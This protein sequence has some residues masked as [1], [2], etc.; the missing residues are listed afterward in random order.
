MSCLPTTNT[1]WGFWGTI[2]HEAEPATA[3]ATAMPAIA[4]ATGCPEEAVRDFLDSRHG[5]HFADDVS[6]DLAGGLGLERAIL[7]AVERWMGWRISRRT[8]RETG[9]PQGLPYLT[10]IVMHA[11][12]EAE[13]A[14]EAA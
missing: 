1:A 10:G 14:A 12:I 3:W 8:A 9:I 5:R 7:A 13:I 6:N 11:A 2:G 4:Q